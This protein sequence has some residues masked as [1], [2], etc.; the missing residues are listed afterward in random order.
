MDR[1]FRITPGLEGKVGDRSLKRLIIII[2]CMIPFMTLILLQT[3]RKNSDISALVFSISLFSVII[4]V[5]V[6]FIRRWG[7]K[8][9]K[10]E[11]FHVTD[12]Y[13]GRSIDADDLKTMQNFN[14]SRRFSLTDSEIDKVMNVTIPWS[15]I[16]SITDKGQF[17][18]IKSKGA[19][20]WKG[21]GMLSLPREIEDYDELEKIIRAKVAPYGVEY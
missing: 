7:I 1:T 10:K 20:T 11:L 3:V 17:L 12:K 6:F 18:L 2:A 13:I 16:E 4:P 5:M 8:A 15:D 9:L 14:D 19:D 21:I